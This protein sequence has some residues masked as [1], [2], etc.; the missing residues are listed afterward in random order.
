MLKCS[1]EWVMGKNE[2]M[3]NSEKKKICISSFPK[4]FCLLN[5]RKT[6]DLNFGKVS[7]LKFFHTIDIKEMAAIF[8]FFHNGQHSYSALGNPETQK[9][10]RFSFPNFSS[11]SVFPVTH[12]RFHF[13]MDAWLR[14]KQF[15]VVTFLHLGN[16][17]H[18]FSIDSV[19]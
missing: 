15:C 13:N 12:P 4:I 11:A 14:L 8:Q 6:R 9:F 17:R 3:E 19:F 2:P 7:N 18:K 5:T 10:C 1:L 16:R